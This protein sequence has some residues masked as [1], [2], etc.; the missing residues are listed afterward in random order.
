MA[1]IRVWARRPWNELE[2]TFAFLDIILVHSSSS[3]GCFIHPM[4]K[5]YTVDGLPFIVTPYSMSS[6][7]GRLSIGPTHE[8]MWLSFD[9]EILQDTRAINKILSCWIM[10]RWQLMPHSDELETIANQI[11]QLV[12]DQIW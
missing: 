6:L 8:S 5:S 11:E 3:P 7:A 2:Y 4:E 10:S 1:R 9:C 12:I